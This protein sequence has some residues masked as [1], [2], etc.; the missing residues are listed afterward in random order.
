MLEMDL[1]A[2]AAQL[3]RE[4]EHARLVRSVTRARRDARDPQP[5][6]HDGTGAESHTERPRRLRL[7]RTA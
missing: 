3:M 5:A 6:G 1:K 2:R 7:P 4:A